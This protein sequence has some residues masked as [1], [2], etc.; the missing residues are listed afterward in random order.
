[1]EEGAEVHELRRSGN[2]T[3]RV[4]GKRLRLRE[5]G[6]RVEEE[7]M[8]LGVGELFWFRNFVAIVELG[9]GSGDSAYGREVV[10][11][12]ASCRGNR[13]DKKVAPSST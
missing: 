4:C 11:D 9:G 6:I 8:F 1:M 3:T 12:Y 10:V 7:L 13:G 5:C 2:N